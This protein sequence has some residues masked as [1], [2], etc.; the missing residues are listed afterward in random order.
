MRKIIGSFVF[1]IA[2]AL[3]N[4]IVYKVLISMI[5]LPLYLDTIFTITVT[6]I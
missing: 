4:M 2:G 5:G 1:C 3:L 6:L